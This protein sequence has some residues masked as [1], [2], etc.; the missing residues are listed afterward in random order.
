MPL[1]I[2]ARWSKMPNKPLMAGPTPQRH[3][4]GPGNPPLLSRSRGTGARSNGSPFNQPDPGFAMLR[5]VASS[6]ETLSFRAPERLEL[7]PTPVTFWRWPDAADRHPE[8]IAAIRRRLY[9]AAR[10]AL[11]DRHN[12]NSAPDVPQWPEPAVQSL[13]RWVAS[14]T[15]AATLGWREGIGPGSFGAWRM[16]GWANVASPNAFGVRRHH[17]SRNW[18][19]TAYYAVDHP[20]VLTFE[21]RGFGI[22]LR[23]AAIRRSR[24]VTLQPGQLAVFPA[25]LEHRVEPHAANGDRIALAFNL[26][27]PALEQSRLWEHR[28][29]WAWRWIP[30]LMRQLAAWRGRPD[31]TPGA[32]PPGTDILP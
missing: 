18:H 4:S 23:E 5:S 12:W 9:V 19:W 25:W 24:R 14:Q 3:R 27:N 32:L 8:I 30:K 20:S 21:D 6:G 31:E 2:M 29:S 10:C 26:H 13:V 11:A 1:N 28:P 16:S 7:F 15:Q 22:D 17:A